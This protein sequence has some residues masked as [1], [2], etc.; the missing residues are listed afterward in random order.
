MIKT[1]LFAIFLFFNLCFTQG[2]FAS[3]DPH[4]ETFDRLSKLKD[5]I[6]LTCKYSHKFGQ[7]KG[8]SSSKIKPIKKEEVQEWFK[9]L[10]DELWKYYRRNED[11]VG[12]LRTTKR[13]RFGKVD[14][15]FLIISREKPYNERFY[16]THTT[17]TEGPQRWIYQSKE[18]LLWTPEGSDRDEQIIFP[19]GLR[20]SLDHDALRG[21]YSY[22]YEGEGLAV[23]MPFHLNAWSSDEGFF[24]FRHYKQPSAMPDERLVFDRTD[25]SLQAQYSKKENCSSYLIKFY[26]GSGGCDKSTLVIVSQCEIVSPK[27]F[28]EAIK[29]EI[30]NRSN[31]LQNAKKVK[32]RI[33]RE[34][35]NKEKV[36]RE[37]KI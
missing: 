6:Y 23:N 14:V 26:F 9:E 17:A 8:R 22:N 15:D 4:K 11:L 27:D 16:T 37:R 19:R 7:I 32:E 10:R 29:N 12:D 24:Y 18:N 1:K 2:L 35:N 3:E 36:I 28:E 33:E 21:I 31:Q 25:L 5:N 34:R 30:V 13:I 20:T